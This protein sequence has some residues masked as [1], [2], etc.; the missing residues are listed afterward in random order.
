MKRTT[1]K[2][3][4]AGAWIVFLVYLASLIYIMFL[5][6]RYGRLQGADAARFN[7]TPLKEIRRFLSNRAVLG[8]RAVFLNVAGNI[9]AFCPFGAILPVMFRKIRSMGQVTVLTAVFSIC[10]ETVQLVTRAGV[11]DVDDILLNTLG[12]MAG[13]TFF[14]FCD[15]LR[16][17]YYYGKQ[18]KKQH[19]P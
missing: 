3:I 15:A 8:G 12:G 18:T 1:A 11:F 5:A 19:L 6:E 13:F 14:C 9:L 10:I 4:R 17:R 2:R 16:R 7:L